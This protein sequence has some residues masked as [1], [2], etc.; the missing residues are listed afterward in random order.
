VESDQELH[1]MTGPL[2]LAAD[3][4]AT[5]T[6]VMVETAATHAV[7]HEAA[8]RNAQHSSLHEILAGFLAA[9]AVVA[10]GCQVVSASLAVAGPT[11]GLHCRMT[12]LSWE[13]DARDL[14]QR[15]SLPTV[16]LLNDVQAAAY[17]V[18]QLT[19][20][21]MV[22]LQAGSVVAGAPRLVI[23]PGSGLGVGFAF[24]QPSG[25]LA[26]PSEA[27]HADFAP[28]DELQVELLDHLRGRFGHVSWER[29]LSGPGLAS[30]FEFLIVRKHA[31]VSSDILQDVERRGGAA[32]TEAALAGSHV[33]ARNALTIF[34]NAYG[35]LAGNLA[36]TMMPRGGIYLAGGITPQIIDAM[37]DGAF[38][39]A[40]A[41]KGRFG[42]A[43]S[44]FPVH[45]VLGRNPSL[46]GA[47]MIARHFAD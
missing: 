28:G 13:I 12:N 31:T 11:D 44:Q 14:V 26:Y 7:V 37:R 1:A 10:A 17:G 38:M 18:G 47:A 8:Y 24:S 32:V 9:P 46:L 5:N 19:S 33:I 4:G 40:Y 3:V 29:V 25:Y 23:A 2:I 45:V 6:R 43:L 15:L 41:A 34:L 21:E 22:R 27:G 39:Q 16:R 20:S 35:A 42:D 30:I 36:L